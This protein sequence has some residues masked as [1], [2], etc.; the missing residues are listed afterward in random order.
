MSQTKLAMSFTAPVVSPKVY[1][2][3]GPSGWMEV[4]QRK[5]LDEDLASFARPANIPELVH[6]FMTVKALNHTETDWWSITGFLSRMLSVPL[7]MIPH[8]ITIAF[9]GHIIS[10]G[11][12]S[13][14]N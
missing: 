2:V 12:G 8:T 4:L 10:L 13:G 5:K 11:L 14:V 1:I 9:W 6:M 3:K 7:E